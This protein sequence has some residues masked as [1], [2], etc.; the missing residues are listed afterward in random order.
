MCVFFLSANHGGDC[1]SVCTVL[2][3]FATECQ[4]IIKKPIQKWRTADRCPVQC[5]F[6][7]VY[8]SC[9]PLCPQSCFQGDDYGDCIADSGCVDGCFCPN[10]QV[11]DNNGQCIESRHCPCL[12]NN[13]IYPQNSRIM[14]QMNGTCH[15]ECECQN[16]SFICDDK[17]ATTTCIT[18]NCTSNQFTCQSDGQCIPLNWKCDGIEDC[19]DGS[20]EL[21]IHCQNQ[22]LNQT[23][24]FQCSNGQCIDVLHRCD[25]ISDCRDGSDEVNCCKMKKK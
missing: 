13:N 20:D 18:T 4:L 5:D 2:S 10:G 8:M 12:Y 1:E 23:K 16:G 15:H 24:T 22:C 6:G 7:K 3:A 21:S 25:G 17:T 11:M 19:L 14:M 9:G